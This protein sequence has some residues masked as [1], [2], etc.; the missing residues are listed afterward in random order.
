MATWRDHARR[1]IAQVIADVGRDDPGRLKR[2]LF[3]AYPFGER[4]YHP[5]RIW[6]DEIKRQTGKSKSVSSRTDLEKLAEFN[7][8]NTEEMP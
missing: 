6:L 3:D 1:V 7:R 4:Q 2:A 8:R 5:Y